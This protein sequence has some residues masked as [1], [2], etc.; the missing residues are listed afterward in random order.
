MNQSAAAVWPHHPRQPYCRY[1]NWLH[2]PRQGQRPLPSPGRRLRQGSCFSS[3]FSI[4]RRTGCPAS[5]AG[6]SVFLCGKPNAAFSRRHVWWEWSPRIPFRRGKAPARPLLRARCCNPLATCLCVVENPHD[7]CP[8]ET[9][10]RQHIHMKTVSVQWQTCQRYYPRRAGIWVSRD[11]AFQVQT[12]PL[13]AGQL[14][15][16]E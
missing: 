2:L 7:Q 9:M 12:E 14:A 10:R 6:R 1:E 3:E 11:R 13:K 15:A 5:T 4:C 16:I 8:S